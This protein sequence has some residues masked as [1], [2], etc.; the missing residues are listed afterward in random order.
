M[1]KKTTAAD[2]A[3]QGEG[4]QKFEGR[5]KSHVPPW[6]IVVVAV[7]FSGTHFTSLQQLKASSASWLFFLTLFPIVWTVTKK[8]HVDCS[9]AF[10]ARITLLYLIVHALPFVPPVSGTGP[11]FTG[12][13][14]S[15][16]ERPKIDRHAICYVGLLLLMLIQVLTWRNRTIHAKLVGRFFAFCY[17]PLVLLE[18]F[19]NAGVVFLTSKVDVL[20]QALG[21]SA[22]LMGRVLS[23]SIWSSALAVPPRMLVYFG[24]SMY[25]LYRQ[26]QL[27]LHI[28]Y[29]QLFVIETLGTGTVRYIIRSLFLGSTC[30]PFGDPL[31]T[32]RIQA[33]AAILM[34]L[35]TFCFKCMVSVSLLPSDKRERLRSLFYVDLAIATIQCLVAWYVGLPLV[36]DCPS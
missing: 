30:E 36:Y 23:V 1:C 4:M 21:F 8:I 19:V 3:P 13:K 20:A 10:L 18:L 25:Y 35:V 15:N 12:L 9:T 6:F 7:I 17:F 28:A 22:S 31:D 27:R 5:W 2:G 16:T 26:R 32:I 14:L 34:G 11:S 29:I 24:M 33:S